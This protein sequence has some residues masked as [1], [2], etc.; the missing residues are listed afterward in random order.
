MYALES[1]LVAR[2]LHKSACDSAQFQPLFTLVKP[3]D[4]VLGQLSTLL[5]ASH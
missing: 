1:E 5:L 3:L 4:L 2:V